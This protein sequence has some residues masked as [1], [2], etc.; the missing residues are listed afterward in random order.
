MNVWKE[1]LRNTKFE[2]AYFNISKTGAWNVF[3]IIEFSF[4]SNFEYSSCKEKH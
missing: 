1:K 3:N 2:F 4:G